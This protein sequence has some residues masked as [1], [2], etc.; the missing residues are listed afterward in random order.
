MAHYIT[1]L[2]NGMVLDKFEL[3]ETVTKI[4]RSAS[5]D[6][7][8]FDPQHQVSRH[9]AVISFDQNRY[10]IKNDRGLCDT[11]VNGTAADEWTSLEQNDAII[12]GRYLLIYSYGYEWRRDGPTLYTGPEVPDS[13]LESQADVSLEKTMG[14]SPEER[15]TFV[16]IDFEDGR[17]QL[18]LQNKF[19]VGRQRSNTVWIQDE[20]VSDIH[21]EIFETAGEWMI[22][23]LQCTS[24]SRRLASGERVQVGN[25]RFRFS[26]QRN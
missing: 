1:L 6:I 5:C 24:N 12:V 20:S 4:G 2:E 9:H 10:W 13:D 25:A 11:L 3:Q 23:D 22:R 19:T 18:I 8:I 21:A 26:V 14:I 16:R 7:R 17:Q 15:P